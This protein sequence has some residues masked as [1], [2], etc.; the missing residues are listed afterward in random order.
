MQLFCF[1]LLVEKS[2]NLLCSRKYKRKNVVVDEFLNND[3]INP[4]SRLPL[5][6]KN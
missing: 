5:V 2:H 1:G 6:E 3:Q 4:E